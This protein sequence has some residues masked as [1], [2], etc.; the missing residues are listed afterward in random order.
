MKNPTDRHLSR[1]ERQIMDIIYA[2]GEASAWQVLEG[3][4]DPPSRTAVRTFLR[5]LEEKGHL[6]HTKKSRE[7]IYQPIRPRVS[8]GQSALKRVLHTFFEGSLEKAVAIHLSDPKSSLP[9]DE[10][11]RLAALIRKTRKKGE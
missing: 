6:V 7:F 2:L 5:I 9:D 10:L 8:A 4:S 1:R 3:M 11:K